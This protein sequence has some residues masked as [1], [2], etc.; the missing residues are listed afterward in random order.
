MG[1][2]G[3]KFLSLHC[4]E[5]G[6]Y[7]VSLGRDFIALEESTNRIAFIISEEDFDHPV[8]AASWLSK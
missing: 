4:A 3:R 2:K 5:D 6:I 1:L 7:C 8:N